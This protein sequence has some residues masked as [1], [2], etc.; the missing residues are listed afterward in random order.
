MQRRP[1]LTIVLIGISV[2][3]ALATDFGD[4]VGT[5]FRSLEFVC[6]D[7]PEASQLKAENDYNGDS[8]NIRLAN[9]KK[10]RFGG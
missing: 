2:V 9:I 5:V 3:V 8:L 7:N 1:T 4:K 6:I 10:G